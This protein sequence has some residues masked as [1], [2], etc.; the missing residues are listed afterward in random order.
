MI[1]RYEQAAA[2]AHAKHE[3]Q[4][5]SVD[6]KVRRAMASKDEVIA[7]L[8]GQVQSLESK[9][10]A[11]EKLLNELHAAISSIRR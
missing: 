10:L 11:S 8:Q 5:A 7:M 1:R 4:L 2:E 6:G 9:N 3:A